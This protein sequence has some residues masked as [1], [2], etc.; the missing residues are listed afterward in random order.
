MV[1]ITRY[2]SRVCVRQEP[3]RLVIQEPDVVVYE[4]GLKDCHV[5]IVEELRFHIQGLAATCLPPVEVPHASQ[6]RQAKLE[7]FT[8]DFLLPAYAHSGL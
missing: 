5:Q 8:V 4:L 1:V 7:E 3:S 6:I 2:V